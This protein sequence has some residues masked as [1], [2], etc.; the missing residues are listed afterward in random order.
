MNKFEIIISGKGAVRAGK[1]LTLFILIEDMD[2]IINIVKSL[3]DS[4][5]LI[6]GIIEA[7]KHEIKK[8]EV[9]P[10]GA[11][12]TRLAVSV[13]QAVISSVVKG[14]NYF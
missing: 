8:Q 13:V 9:R 11:L 5:L 6:D 10:V 14:I 4:G 1:R 12:I 3:E 7:V 2:D